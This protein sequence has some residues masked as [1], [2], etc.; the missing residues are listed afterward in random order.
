M[1]D[2][3]RKCDGRLAITIHGIC[4]AEQVIAS[5]TVKIAESVRTDSSRDANSEETP[6]C[7]SVAP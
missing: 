7:R 6:E 4:A 2:L 3:V 5:G 1:K